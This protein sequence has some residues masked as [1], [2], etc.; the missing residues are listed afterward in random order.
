[1]GKSVLLSC[2]SLE[3]IPFPTSAESNRTQATINEASE[4]PTHSTCYKGSACPSLH[5]AF[6]SLFRKKMNDI[7]LSAFSHP[8]S[9]KYMHV[10]HGTEYKTLNMKIYLKMKS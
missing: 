9:S 2:N 6:K 8:N 1:M 7:W 5:P 4:L 10:Y 3:L